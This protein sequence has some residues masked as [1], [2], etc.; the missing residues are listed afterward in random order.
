[1][2]WPWMPRIGRE[3]GGWPREMRKE[4]RKAPTAPS[5]P[6]TR[7]LFGEKLVTVV[8]VIPRRCHRMALLDIWW[9][10]I[11][12]KLAK[13]HQIS[14]LLCVLF[15]HIFTASI[16]FHNCIIVLVHYLT[17]QVHS[18]FKHS[19]IFTH[20]DSHPSHFLATVNVII[21]FDLYQSPKKCAPIVNFSFSPATSTA[22]STRLDP[23]YQTH[24]EALQV[25]SFYKWTK[26]HSRSKNKVQ[27]WDCAPRSSQPPSWAATSRPCTLAR[28]Y[29]CSVWQVL[30]EKSISFRKILPTFEL[31]VC[32]TKIQNS[33]NVPI[34]GSS[35]RMVML[36]VSTASVWRRRWWA[37]R[38]GE[39]IQTTTATTTQ[40]TTD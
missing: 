19:P 33:L 22:S 7:Q 10:V 2:T 13:I 17:Y 12:C 20:I 3:W 9:I 29:N 24:P 34:Q 8:V 6:T 15:N 26:L 11:S 18:C 25:G 28:P 38:S 14:G 21:T 39:A 36:E 27:D 37:G 31:T 35:V 4:G 32:N 30:L 1:M 16:S 23:P 40:P 5:D